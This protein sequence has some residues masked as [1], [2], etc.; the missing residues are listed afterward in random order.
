VISLP[1]VSVIIPNY[2]HAP[3]LRE[4]IESVLN[5]TYENF[6]V[7]ILDDCS[8]D[9]SREVIAAFEG[10]P[11]IAVIEFNKTNSGTTFK[12]W[13]KGIGLAS[14]EWI[15]IAESD[16][17]C[18]P[19]L[20]ENLVG[21]IDDACS[22]AFCQ[23]VAVGNNGV[24]LWT[25]KADRMAERL[26]GDQFVHDKMLTGC[27]IFNASMSIFK[28]SYYLNI[29]KEF[30]TFKFCGDWLFWILMLMQ[31]DVFICGKYLNYF[32][33][34]DKDV[35][36]KAFSSGLLYSEYLKLLGILVEKNIIGLGVK[37]DLCIKKY[38]EL[39]LDVRINDA[40]KSDM[41]TSYLKEIGYDVFSKKNLVF[42]GRR[43]YVKTLLKISSI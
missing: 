41:M 42:F 26:A 28:K 4:R 18:E 7:I 10:H 32:R 31:G 39:V 11:K 14:G 25:G 1:K 36:G 29:S 23:S 2:N 9:N 30:T 38:K 6:E 33:K 43:I 3:Y 40:M 34:H 5:Q 35:S 12:Q 16:D 8:Q 37:K 19:T 15:W 24:C 22:V 21:N 27:T 17:W 20:L 13:E